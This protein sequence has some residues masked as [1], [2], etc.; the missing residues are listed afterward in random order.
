MFSG[1][2]TSH[3][4]SDIEVDYPLVNLKKRSLGERSKE[5]SCQRREEYVNRRPVSVLMNHKL[6]AKSSTSQV[7]VHQ[8]PQEWKIESVQSGRR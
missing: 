4:V 7:E 3:A 1:K 6:T 2:L 8:A 5:N